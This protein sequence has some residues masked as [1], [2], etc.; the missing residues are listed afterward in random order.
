MSNGHPTADDRR[1]TARRFR[2]YGEKR[3]EIAKVIA[4]GST[5]TDLEAAANR[6]L[7]LAE[8]LMRLNSIRVSDMYDRWLEATKRRAA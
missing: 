4:A 3:L 7:D 6:A 1:D 5:D 8:H 2:E